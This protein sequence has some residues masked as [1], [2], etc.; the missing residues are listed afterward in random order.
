MGG[1]S[2]AVVMLFGVFFIS[3]GWSA[4]I[5]DRGKQT[6]RGLISCSDSNNRPERAKTQ[7]TFVEPRIA[8][9]RYP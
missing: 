2:A 6:Q 1:W 4:M 8:L 3:S 9:Q 7:P 5:L